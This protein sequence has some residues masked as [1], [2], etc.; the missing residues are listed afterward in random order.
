MSNA[1]DV[2]FSNVTDLIIARL[3][4]YPDEVREISI[5]AIKASEHL[6]EQA[7]ADQIMA[8]ARDC[9]NASEGDER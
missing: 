9:A 5:R 3:S 6:P 7:I 8:L 4:G 2:R 1:G